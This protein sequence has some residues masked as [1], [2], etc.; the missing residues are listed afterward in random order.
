ML[1]SMLMMM[2]IMCGEG[3]VIMNI[4]SIMN[5]G[6]VSNSRSEY[7]QLSSNR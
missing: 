7:L 4:G 3:K 6:G 1:D 5:I 2:M